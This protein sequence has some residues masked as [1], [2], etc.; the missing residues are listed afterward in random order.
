ML[1]GLWWPWLPVAGLAQHTPMTLPSVMAE[2]PMATRV[3]AERVPPHR[4]ARPRRVQPATPQPEILLLDVSI[5]NQRLQG[6]VH[7]EQMPS[8]LLLLPLEA[9]QQARLVPVSQAS[10]LS[11]GTP[12]Y[13]LDTV[14]GVTYS[15][16][17]QNLSMEINAPASAFIGSTL[18]LQGALAAPPPRPNPGMLINY[19][20]S[21]SVASHGRAVTS[22]ALLEA[23]AFNRLGNFA[24][25][26]LVRNA[27]GKRSVERLDTTWRYDMPERLETLVAGDTVG[28]SGGWSR[29]AR[30]GGV[31]W[32][33]D[34]GQRPGFVTYPQLTLNGEAALSSTVDIWV[35][36]ARRSSQPVQPGPFELSNVPIVTGAGDIKLVVRDLLGRE[37]VIQ[38]SYYAAPRLL[39]KG[40]TDFS[41]EAGWLRSGYG[42]DSRYADVFGAATWRQ[43]LSQRLTGEA[44]LELQA[45][46]RA[47]GVEL[48]GL[49]G[50][51]AVGRVALAASGTNTQGVAEQGRLLQ[52]GIERSASG[53]GGALQYE[54]AS[55]G[56]APFGKPLG[57][58]ALGQ[59]ARARWLASLGGL[60]WGP[61][62]GS[63]SYVSQT[64][65]DN[66]QVKS[67]GLSLS[68]PL[69]QRASLSLS[70]NK[71]LDG[72]RVWR[73]GLS[74]TLP[75][76]NGINTS[77]RVE[78]GSDSRAM[79]TVSASRNPPAGPGLGWQ[80]ESS[81]QTSQHARGGLHYNTS[82]AEF[83]ADV[84]SDAKGQLALRA[85]TRGTLGLLA[86]LPFA[87]RAVGQGSFAVID[88]GGLVGVP[89][90]RSH[91][92][93]AVTN[94]RGLAF[95]PGLLPWHQNRIE[96]DPV[97]LPLDVEVDN[98][99]QQIT[100][101]PGSGSLVKFAVHRTRQALVVLQQ[102]DG[103]PVPV[104]TQVRLLPDGPEFIAGRRGEVWL[105]GLAPE[106]QGLQVRW[107][108]GGCKL[109]LR[110]PG[111]T[112][113]ATPKKI[114][115]LVCTKE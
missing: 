64:R 80:V 68:V 89:V 99:V 112:D 28:V 45:Q 91:Q 90:M 92:V 100:P 72:D 14:P 8:G 105:T 66:E 114:G 10:T 52:L 59:R 4:A 15:I 107:P 12:G 13:A 33:R 38:Q 58:M 62:S 111:A 108:G 17:R 73:A 93:V 51:W 35:N 76:D 47:A 44:R 31:R 53:G 109:E 96:V 7:V 2:L 98:I 115:P 55:R 37:T 75:L 43:G 82:Q 11:D 85:S 95:V 83:S 106:R 22:G 30:Y 29:P 41:F 104:G 16:N 39:E 57:P 42:Q 48:S 86:G 3:A 97:D 23:I 87:S 110:L 26:A 79:G 74:I 50:N 27:E 67:A 60:V 21:L 1:L 81:T 63:L 78:T 34:F 20:I 103:A 77:M 9:W 46:R 56:F 24:S 40:L 69:L 113:N 32:G 54:H 101:Y 36:N 94:S 70:L 71:R 5:N 88:A 65:W 18:G 49:L 102:P 6:V 19:D 25:S 61:V 84:V